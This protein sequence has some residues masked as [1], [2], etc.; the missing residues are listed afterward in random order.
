[1]I[2]LSKGVV[3]A[4]L[5]IMLVIAHPCRSEEP[6][7]SPNQTDSSA[8]PADSANPEELARKTQN[9]VSDLISIPIENLFGFEA[10]RD[11]E[12]SYSLTLKP[13]IPQS[14]NEEWNWIHRALIPIAS[15]PGFERERCPIAK[16]RSLE[17]PLRGALS[18]FLP[19]GLDD[20]CGL[21]DIQYQGYLSPAKP[22]KWI[23]GVGPVLEFPT[24]TDDPL[25]SEKWSAGIGGVLLRS[26]GHWVYGTLVNNIWSYAGN[27]DRDY[28]NRMTIQPFIN[29]NFKGGVYLTSAPVM[30]AS[31]NADSED[32]WKIPIGGGAGKI[33]KVGKLPLNL[34][35]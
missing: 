7:P 12:L 29:Y 18:D 31:W 4:V 13:V 6:T 10:G 28:V 32:I 11:G 14:L 20:A 5:S 23:W 1:M 3:S 15:Q 17:S 19:T 21:G 27:S 22:E 16:L 25:G 8:A 30:T 2:Q 24:A 34:T 26:E 9:P 35:L 33:I